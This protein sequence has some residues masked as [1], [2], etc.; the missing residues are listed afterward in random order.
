M[1]Y[2]TFFFTIICKHTDICG[3]LYNSSPKIHSIYS[4]F[5]FFVCKNTGTCGVL[6][7]SS[8]KTHGI[9]GIF[10]SKDAGVLYSSKQAGNLQKHWYLQ[11]S[12]QLESKNS[13][14]L[15]NFCFFLCQNTGI[16]SVLCSS[17][18]KT[19]DI[20][21]I[22]CSKDASQNA[23]QG[24]I[25]PERHPFATWYMTRKNAQKTRPPLQLFTPKVARSAKA[26]PRPPSYSLCSQTATIQLAGF[27][28]I[29]YI[30]T[31][32]HTIPYHTI[33]YH[34]IPYHSIPY[35]TYITYITLHYITLHYITL[36]NI[37]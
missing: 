33:L 5:C 37:T 28:N 18:P 32:Y 36:H 14:Y 35:H 27:R 19:H 12:V 11:C 21:S 7:S 4:I 16:C 10:C 34:T 22:F 24:G 3:V 30:H 6:C 20:Y 15:R 1:L 26:C 31:Y 29:T 8:P 23:D 2:F 17:S 25:E 9:Y 13:W